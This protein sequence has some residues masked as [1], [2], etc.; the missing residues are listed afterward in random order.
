[1]RHGWFTVLALA[2]TVVFGPAVMIAAD[3][4][5]PPPPPVPRDLPVVKAPVVT[6]PMQPAAFTRRGSS[7][8]GGV[9]GREGEGRGGLRR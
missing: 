5:S 7:G 3:P 9:Q 2:V 6:R 4:V 1:M 8:S